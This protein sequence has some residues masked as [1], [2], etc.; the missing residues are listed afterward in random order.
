MD[1]NPVEKR[2]N[3]ISEIIAQGS[4]DP[5]GGPLA[6]KPKLEVPRQLP[7]S[8][9][10][11]AK[12][13]EFIDEMEKPDNFRILFG[14]RTKKDVRNLFPLNDSYATIVAKRLLTF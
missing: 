12:V 10:N 9:N 4:E 14:K 8:S 11:S 7:W 2:K 3:A 13:H 1:T 6:K 5:S